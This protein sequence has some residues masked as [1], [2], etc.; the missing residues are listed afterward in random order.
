[1]SASREVQLAQR[2]LATLSTHLKQARWL[3]RLP[4]TV[5]GRWEAV[6]V[7][8]TTL[9]CSLEI[10]EARINEAEAAERVALRRQGRKAR[11]A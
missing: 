5:I 10:L 8:A 11:A 6:L 9:G 4:A 7:E 1:M 3:H 2:A